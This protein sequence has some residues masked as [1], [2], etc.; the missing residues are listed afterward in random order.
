VTMVGPGP[1]RGRKR[2]RGRRAGRGRRFLAWL[3]GLVLL[4]AVFFAGLAIG[5]ALEEAPQPGGTQTR[6]RTI[7]PLTVAPQERTVTVTTGG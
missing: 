4:A 2:P 7:E 3:L 5:R 6:V 1:A